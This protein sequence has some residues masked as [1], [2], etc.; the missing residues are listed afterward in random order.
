M[1][2]VKS[3][4]GLALFTASVTLAGHAL[5][6]ERW[7][8]DQNTCNQR[9]D[10]LAIVDCLQART[11]FWDDRLNQSW[12]ALNASLAGDRAR[13]S[14]LKAAQLAWIKYRD[15]NCAYYYSEDGTI[16]QIDTAMCQ[17]RMTQDRAIELQGEL[18]N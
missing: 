15:A 6:A 3:K 17:L 2:G 8:P 7:A 4:V 1:A 10:T 5:A 16:K 11:K 12:K 14:T 13:L 18:P 9:P